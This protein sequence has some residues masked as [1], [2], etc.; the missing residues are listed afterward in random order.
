MGKQTKY[1]EEKLDRKHEIISDLKD[2]LQQKEAV[3][4]NLKAKLREKDSY[5]INLQ[6]A[7]GKLKEELDKTTKLHKESVW[8]SWEI[9]QATQEKETEIVQK[10]Q[11]KITETTKLLNLQKK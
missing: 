5:I 1:F 2:E 10:T 8:Q 6:K 9:I 7:G 4:G 3:I 11:K